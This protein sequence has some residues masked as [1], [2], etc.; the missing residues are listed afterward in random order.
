MSEFYDYVRGLSNTVPKGYSEA[1]MRVYRYLVHLGA[2]QL[3]EASFPEVKKTLGDE[4]WTTLIEAFVKQSGWTSHYYGDLT[5]EF[6]QFL[7]EQSE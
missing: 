6:F 5:D 7:Q 4:N 2:T 1:G 3:L